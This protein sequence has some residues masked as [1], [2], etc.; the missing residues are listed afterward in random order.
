MT[1]YRVIA[2][3]SSGFRTVGTYNTKKQAETAEK[4]YPFTLDPETDECPEMEIE[5]VVR[6]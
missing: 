3:T 4:A 1:T 2:K 6:P 5:Q